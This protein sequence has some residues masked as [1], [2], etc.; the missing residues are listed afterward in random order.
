MRVVGDCDTTDTIRIEGHIEGSVRAQKAVVIGKA[1]R[2]NGD[3]HTE[4]A[5]IGGSVQGSLVV[6]S[7]LELQAT[8]Q[9]DGEI[10]AARL[11]LEEGGVVNGTINVGRKDAG[12]A[13]DPGAAASGNRGGVGTKQQGKVLGVGG[14]AKV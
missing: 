8:C 2:V 4:D 12:V 7:R 11:Q 6:E 5:V 13:I 1:G 3:I 14:K 10:S 9:I